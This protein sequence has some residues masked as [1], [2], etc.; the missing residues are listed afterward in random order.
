M[1]VSPMQPNKHRDGPLTTKHN[2]KIYIEYTALS[3]L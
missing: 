2:F 1:S 3:G